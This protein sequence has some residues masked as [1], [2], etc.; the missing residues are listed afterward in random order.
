MSGGYTFKKG[1]SFY[2]YSV[3]RG[4]QVQLQG[5]QSGFPYYSLTLRREFLKKKGA[6]GLGV[7]NFLS[8]GITVKNYVQS[9]A[10]SQQSTTL[11]HT[12]SFRLNL[13]FRIGKLT[14]EKAER[15]KKSIGNDDL[16]QVR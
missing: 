8:P 16:K 15:K 6:I 12:L 10:L 13:C 3:Y 7:E 11:T 2:I 14:M 5:Y 9:A 1:W 4:E